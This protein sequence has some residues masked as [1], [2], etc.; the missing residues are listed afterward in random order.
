M[1]REYLVLFGDTPSHTHLIEHDIDV[2]DS[3]PIKQRFYRCAPHRQK[4]MASEIKYMLDNHIAVPS[5]SSWAS[6]CPLV[7]KSDKSP[8]FCTDYRKVNKVTKSDSFLLPR[9]ED[10]IDQ[11]GAAK[12]V[13]KFDL[14]K[15]YWQVPLSACAREIYAFIMPTGLYE[16]TVMSFG[17]WNAPATFQRLMNMVVIGLEGCAVYLDDVVIFSDTWDAHVQCVHA[18]FSRLAE[19]RLTVNLE[20]CE[21]ARVTVTYLGQVVG[22][23]QVR[24]VDAKVRAVVQFPIPVTKKEL[25]HFLAFV[26]YYRSFCKNFSTVGESR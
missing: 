1:I 26:G 6:P 24:P 21:F 13:S 15:G 7:D 22:Q 4:V 25:M 18:F 12:F 10:C 3:T 11:V 16:Y 8:R 14:L 17:L 23:G 19:A 9:M 5:S 20:K 2:G